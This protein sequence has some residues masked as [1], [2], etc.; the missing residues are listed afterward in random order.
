MRVSLDSTVCGEVLVRIV[1]SN[2][3]VEC[4]YSGAGFKAYCCAQGDVVRG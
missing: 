4:V 2:S 1:V 3:V